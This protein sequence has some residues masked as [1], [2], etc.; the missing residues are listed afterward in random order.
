M[1]IAITIT[2]NDTIP[3]IESPEPFSS[4]VISF[5]LYPIFVYVSRGVGSVEFAVLFDNG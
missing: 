1:I 5:A 4:C 2:T 3:A